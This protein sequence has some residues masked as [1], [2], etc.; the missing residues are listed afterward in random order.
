MNQFTK[1]TKIT[2]ILMSSLKV[3]IPF[4]S[5]STTVSV[6]VLKIVGK[7]TWINLENH[8]KC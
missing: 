8:S 6:V 5:S 7:E 4:S 3:F 2:L 1:N